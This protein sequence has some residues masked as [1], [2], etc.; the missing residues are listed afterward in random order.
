MFDDHKKTQPQGAQVPG[1]LPIGEPDDMFSGV[2]APEAPAVP[3]PIVE[4]D[5]QSEATEAAPAAPEAPP[6][7]GTALGAGILKPKPAVPQAPTSVPEIQAGQAP[8]MSQGTYGLKEPTASRAIMLILGI[9]IG[10]I[11][12]VGG[13]WFM[14][15]TF[16]KSPEPAV[17]PSTGNLIP[18]QPLGSTLGGNEINTDSGELADSVVTD[19]AV[20]NTLLFGEPADT[21]ADGL[22]D[23]REGQLETDPNHWDTDD[24][25]LSDGEEVIIWKTNPLE[26]D[27]DADGYSD[28]AE[29]KAGY[30]PAG[31]G[32]LFEPPAAQ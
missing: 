19:A 15:A 23:V 30:N 32:R 14:Y 16:I 10:L 18:T 20:D 4:A 11:V 21:D 7:A 27:T 3:A 2:D 24:D 6:A 1:N 26:A 28:G 12:L 8:Q 29:V 22:D 9:S 5:A 17:S 31:E 25:G 13:G